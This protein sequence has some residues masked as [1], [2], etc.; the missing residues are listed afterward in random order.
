MSILTF[1]WLL[2]LAQSAA[3]GVDWSSAPFESALGSPEGIST[4]LQTIYVGTTGEEDG[5]P[6]VSTAEGENTQVSQSTMLRWT[7]P[8][9]VSNIKS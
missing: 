3:V 1:A 2:G 7:I 5:N 9:N 8:R 6:L 4:S